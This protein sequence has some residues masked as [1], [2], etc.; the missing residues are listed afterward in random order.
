MANETKHFLIWMATVFMF[1]EHL[2][3]CC[4]IKVPMEKKSKLVLCLQT[5][6]MS[7][8]SVTVQLSLK[9]WEKHV[10]F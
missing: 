9:F 8:T 10:L 1:S 5:R 6:V 4:R 7:N 3:Y 2:S